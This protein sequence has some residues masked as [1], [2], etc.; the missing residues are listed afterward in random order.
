MSL[1]RINDL[2]KQFEQVRTE[3]KSGDGRKIGDVDLWAFV[4]MVDM[5]G[6]GGCEVCG[7]RYAGTMWGE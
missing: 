7:V 1:G 6:S 3:C 2:V 5:K 4:A